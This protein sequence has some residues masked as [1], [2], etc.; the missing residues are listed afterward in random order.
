MSFFQEKLFG[1]EKMEKGKVI[2]MSS[3]KSDVQYD[4]SKI[5]IEHRRMIID[6][7]K[8]FVVASDAEMNAIEKGK[9]YYTDRY[10]DTAKG[11]VMV[12]RERI[13]G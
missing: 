5:S 11:W 8:G 1:G 9:E 12:R 4:W 7:D 13:Q 10:S 3:G 2:Q 6:R